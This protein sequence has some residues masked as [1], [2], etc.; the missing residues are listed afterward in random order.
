MKK[1]ADN[2]KSA[3]I[4]RIK[5]QG[6]QTVQAPHQSSPQKKGNVKTGADL[7]TGKK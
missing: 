3:Y 6:S 7:R 4:G 2:G 1:L 5:N